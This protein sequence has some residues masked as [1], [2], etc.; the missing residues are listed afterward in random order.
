MTEVD[1]VIASTFDKAE[2]DERCKATAG[3]LRV[4]YAAGNWEPAEIMKAI[5]ASRKTDEAN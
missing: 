4:L 2:S 1:D 5:A 3:G